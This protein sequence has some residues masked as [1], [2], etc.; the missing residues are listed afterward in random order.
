MCVRL[1]RGQ[2]HNLA[3]GIMGGNGDSSRQHPIS[4][5]IYFFLAKVDTALDL[6]LAPD[7]CFVSKHEKSLGRWANAE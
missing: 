6:D 1:G 3:Y 2:M 5:V 7:Y 4:R